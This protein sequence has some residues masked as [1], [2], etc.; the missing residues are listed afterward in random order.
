[1][2][3]SNFLPE[4]FGFMTREGKFTNNREHG[5][6]TPGVSFIEAKSEPITCLILLIRLF[7]NVKI[8]NI[9]TFIKPFFFS[10]NFI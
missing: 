8:L 3:Y 4:V 7:I 10:G 9:R 2:F 5:G 1:M 6:T